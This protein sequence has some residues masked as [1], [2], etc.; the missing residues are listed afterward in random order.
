MTKCV[1]DNDKQTYYIALE[2]SLTQ[3]LEFI[4]RGWSN[5]RDKNA[6]KVEVKPKN[7]VPSVESMELCK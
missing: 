5:H 7:N 2:R 6:D 4:A 3:N 1:W